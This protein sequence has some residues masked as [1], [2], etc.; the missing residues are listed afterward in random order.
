MPVGDVLRLAHERVQHVA[1]CRE[2]SVD[3]D[4]LVAQTTRCLG[5]TEPLGTGEVDEGQLPLALTARAE[6][7]VE[8]DQVRAARDRVEPVIGGHAPLERARHE[9]ACRLGARHGGPR[10][11]T[12]IHLRRARSGTGAG[13]G[14]AEGE[15][16]T[17]RGDRVGRATEVAHFIHVHL[18]QA[19]SEGGGAPV[20]SFACPELSQGEI[21]QGTHRVRLAT[22]GLAVGED[23]GGCAG[24]DF[25]RE[26]LQLLEDARRRG[27]RREDAVKLEGL[28]GASHCLARIRSLHHY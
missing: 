16:S 21:V 6:Q 10:Q 20:G 27:L 13:H 2:R 25:A 26:R 17:G 8:D 4:G 11:R 18:C 15:F 7:R 19:N 12:C 23:G 14:A 9:G 24:G 22:T 1:E 3:R 28:D 5:T